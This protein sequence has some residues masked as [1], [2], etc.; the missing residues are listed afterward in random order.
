MR[1]ADATRPVLV[2]D[3]DCGFCRYWVDYWRQLTGAAIEY[4]SYQEIGSHYPD[5]SEAEFARA[6]YLF[7][8]DGRRSRGAEAAFE[9][10]ARAPGRG[11]WRAAYRRVPGFALVAEAAYAVIARHRGAAA[12]LS[13]VLWGPV[14]EPAQV[15]LMAGLFLRLLGLVYLFAFASFAVQASGLIGA[16]GVLPLADFAQAVR[17]QLGDDAWWQVPSVL[18][19]APGE[20]TIRWAGP[21]GTVLAGALVAGYA[22]RVVLPLL[23]VL[24]LGIVHAGQTFFHFQWDLLL[25]EVGFL[26]IFL[27]GASSLV[28]WLLRWLC[29]RFLFLAGIAKLLSGDASWWSWSALDY[30]FQT[31]PLPSVLAWYAHHLPAGLHAL[32]TAA[33]LVIEI[34]LP[35]L[36]FLPRR[37]RF[38]F[39]ACVL[40]LELLILLTG[41]YNFFNLLTMLLC[42]PLLDDAALR[43]LPWLARYE[44]RLAVPA[45]APGRSA[46]IG[47]GLLALALVGLGVVQ[48]YEQITRQRAWEPL[49]RAY[50]ALAGFG[51]VNGYG[52]FAN[53]T[54][55]RYEIVIEGTQDGRTWTPYEFR[56]KPGDPARAP[57]WNVPHQPRL[58]WQMWFAAL[59]S[60]PENPWFENLLLRLLDGSPP[61]VALFDRNPF[62]DSPPTQVR[63]RLYEYRYTSAAERAATGAWWR[64]RELGL[65][66]PPIGR[67]PAR[68]Q[69][70]APP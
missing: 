40:V 2:Y 36:V 35:F 49:S 56:Y 54:T 23:Y 12:T 8:P 68:V 11:V 51:I 42:L 47:L 15:R 38:A 66:F 4:R 30:H 25:L 31:Q 18:L 24:Y 17:A 53:M 20:T 50:R 22:P 45:V 64:R 44:T 58:D 3:G 67:G 52:L 33:T 59:G 16:Q 28:V 6:I 29:F 61:V 19:L 43:R 41:S 39:A 57:G 5:V 34:L 48:G 32:G 63:A 37:P 62:P 21:L 60:A 9:V 7:E 14:R 10:L 70:A 1:D 65:Y 55:T 69:R 46:R 26:A 27:P 13:R